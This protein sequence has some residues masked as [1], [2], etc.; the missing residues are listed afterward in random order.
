VNYKY[1]KSLAYLDNEL[2]SR[3]DLVEFEKNIFSG[4]EYF[5]E[6]MR[7]PSISINEKGKY[8]FN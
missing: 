3:P 6:N 4:Y 7:L 8:I 1:L 5:E 2:K